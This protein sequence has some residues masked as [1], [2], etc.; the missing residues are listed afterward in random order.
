MSRCNA[1]PR[2]TTRHTVHQT[3]GANKPVL[4][5]RLRLRSRFAFSLKGARLCLN[6]QLLLTILERSLFFLLDRSG[7]DGRFI[8][9]YVIPISFHMFQPS[10]ISI[11]NPVTILVSAHEL[12]I[13]STTPVYNC[14]YLHEYLWR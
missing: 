3:P 7:Y 1:L 10:T 12:P 6:Y 2:R 11:F 13:T 9:N 8:K 4:L 5:F 14:R